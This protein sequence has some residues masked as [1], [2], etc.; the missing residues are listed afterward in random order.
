MNVLEYL[1]RIGERRL[2]RMRI[3]PP[4]PRDTRMLLGAL[5]FIGYYSLVIMIMK[6]RELAP[7][8]ATLVKDAMLV[9]GPVVG[10]IAQALFRT[11][12]RDEIAT[13]NTGA[14]FRALGDQA[15]ATVAAAAT[16]PPDAS[17]AAAAAEV[18]DAATMRADQIRDEV[19]P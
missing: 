5:F 15:K 11:D 13:N 18:A 16:T 7:D 6:G 14:A 8:N 9:L 3:A 12:V 4:R 19:Q 17:V 2:E 10:M 1:D